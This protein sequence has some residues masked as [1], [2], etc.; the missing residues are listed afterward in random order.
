MKNSFHIISILGSL[1]LLFLSS[2]GQKTEETLPIRKDVTETV[3][4]AGAL[5]AEGM[6]KLT[7]QTNGYLTQL[8]F[9]EGKIVEKGTVLAVIENNENVINTKG[10][11]ELLDIAKSNTSATAPLL[12]QAEHE[13]EISLQKMEQ[14]KKTEARYKRLLE[15]KSIARV[16]YENALLAYQTSKSSYE[17]AL[18]NYKR[19][20]KDAEQQVVNNQTNTEIYATLMG[21]NKVKAVIRGKVYEKYKEVGDYVRQGDVIAQIG[22]PEVL[23]AKVNI[24]EANISRIKTGQ[25]AVIQLNTDKEKKFKG[26]VKEIKPTFDEASQ[27]FICKIYFQDTLDFQIVNTQLQTNIIVG[28]QKDAL[29]IPRNYIDFGGYVQVKGQEEKTKVSTQFISNEWVQVLSGIDEHTTL[30]TA[31]LITHK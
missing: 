10:A 9:E 16:E 5:E 7:A 14:D 1:C 27:S 21:K 18:E 25:E 12:K 4:A 29:L 11:S 2:C 8:N 30:V 28:E 22:S 15:S 23:Y 3:F 19:L 20:K 31:N 26:K 13:I 17:S 24:D 6:Y